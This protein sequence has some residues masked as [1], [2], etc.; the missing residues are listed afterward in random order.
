MLGGAFSLRSDITSSIKSHALWGQNAA[1]VARIA[2]AVEDEG[3]VGAPGRQGRV[4]RGA[5][6]AVPPVRGSISI[7]DFLGKGFQSKT[8]YQ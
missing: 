5:H 2:D 4:V 8:S 7:P 3:D 1:W 6:G